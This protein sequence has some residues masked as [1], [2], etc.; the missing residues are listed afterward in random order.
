MVEMKASVITDEFSLEFDEVCEYLQGQDMEYIELRKVWIGN[1]VQIDDRTLGDAKDIINDAGLKVSCIAG[2]LLKC[3]PPSVNPN[4]KSKVDYSE[5]WKYNYSL[6]DRAIEVAD[7]FDTTYIRCFGYNGKWPKKEVSEWDE[8]EI[9][10]DWSEILKKMK[11]KLISAN[12]MFVCENE[13]GLNRSLENMEKIGQDQVDEGFGL[14]YD[15]ANVANK[16]GEEGILTDEWLDRLGKYIQ[17]IH[18]KGT[19]PKLKGYATTYVNDEKDICRWPE[20]L[21]Y[22][23][24]RS[25]E[26]FIAPAPNPLFLS[27]ETHMGKKNIWEKSEQSLKNLRALLE[28]Y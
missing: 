28:T 10:Q 23:S 26:D 25:A 12:K 18:A 21:D 16:F 19:K 8:W 2:P 9:Y 11:E 27:I 15:M 5:N 14:L 22:F 24:Q 13:G 1:I 3:L 7:L 4:P 17:Y 20:V 6:L